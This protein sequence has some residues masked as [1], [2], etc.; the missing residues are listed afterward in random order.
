MGILYR[1]VGITGE[2]LFRFSTLALS[3]LCFS[4]PKSSLN[5]SLFYIKN[6][7]VF[8]PLSRRWCRRSRAE[9]L[10]VFV[11]FLFFLD[12]YL[13]PFLRFGA[14]S[15]PSLHAAGH[16]RSTGGE[17]G[18]VWRRR[19]DDGGAAC[20]SFCCQQ[21]YWRR[22]Q[23]RWADDLIAERGGSGVSN[24]REYHPEC[25]S[26]G[27]GYN[28]CGAGGPCQPK[29]H[30]AGSPGIPFPA[31]MSTAHTWLHCNSSKDAYPEPLPSYHIKQSS[32]RLSIQVPVRKRWHE[33][34]GIFYKPQLLI[35][36]VFQSSSVAAPV[37]QQTLFP[38]TGRPSSL[39]Y[40]ADEPMKPEVSANEDMSISSASQELRI[41]GASATACPIHKRVVRQKQISTLSWCFAP[42]GNNNVCFSTGFPSPCLQLRDHNGLDPVPN[43]KQSL[44]PS[45]VHLP[46][47][48]NATNLCEND[49]EVDKGWVMILQ[50]ELRNS[51]VGSLGRIVLPKR[52]CEANLPPLFERSGMILVMEDLV[53][54]LVWEFKYRGK[55]ASRRLQCIDQAEMNRREQGNSE[56]GS[57]SKQQLKN[58]RGKSVICPRCKEHESASFV[59]PKPEPE[60]SPTN[61]TFG[62]ER[63]VSGPSQ[64]NMSSPDFDPEM[65]SFDRFLP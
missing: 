11:F 21:Q 36:G 3:I 7:Q 43:L 60:A 58:N 5:L 30:R 27:G 17:I 19:L 51:D 65:M 37:Q 9:K 59:T 33:F 44:V 23:Q 12:I 46:E 15:S 18:G 20:G 55:K 25:E 28:Q 48:L 22:L 41:S 64:F 45:L 10:P 56:K 42:D 2:R 40:C 61:T 47:H 62:N 38:V 6:T 24:V 13:F 49:K 53:P 50:K 1:I 26:G 35:M 52:D 14:F 39:N 63:D 31:S 29:V 54:P 57:T 34:E 16:H 32:L 8:F 4:P